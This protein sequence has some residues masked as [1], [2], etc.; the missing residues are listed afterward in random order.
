MA[1]SAGDWVEVRSKEEILRTLDKNAQLDAMPFMPQMFQNCGKRFKVLKR[2]H[3]TCDTIKI[4]RDYP[5]RGVTDAVHLDLRCDGRAYGGCQAACLI[6][7]KEQWLTPVGGPGEQTAASVGRTSDSAGDRRCTEADVRKATRA[8]SSKPGDD[9]VYVCQATRLLDYTKPLPWWDARQYVEDY[10]SG[11]ASFLQILRGLIYVCYYYSTL[12]FSRRFGAPARWVYDRFQSLWGGPPYP[13]H[14]G[15]LLSGQRAP[16][17]SLNLQ[18]GEIVRV[19]SYEEILRTLDHENMNRGMRFDG[20]EVPF[21]GRTYRVRNRVEKFIDERTG[22]LR[23]MKTPAVIL[24]GVY[25][26]GRYS[27][28][29]MFCPRGILS[30]WREVWL[31][32]VH[33]GASQMSYEKEPDHASMQLQYH[34]CRHEERAIDPLATEI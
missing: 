15:K 28:H 25:C 22:K 5:G 7:W 27:S 6:F 13:R 33:E 11:N 3:K 20:E 24:E 34:P 9:P 14:R 23:T 4:N 8:P 29:R 16:I 21:C 17:S 30:W 31:D 19:K 18:P 1:L 2:A 10:T 26:Q 32:R 12:S